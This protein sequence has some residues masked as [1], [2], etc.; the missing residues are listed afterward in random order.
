LSRELRSARVTRFGDFDIVR[1]RRTVA[2]TLVEDCLVM[3]ATMLSEERRLPG[4]TLRCRF[5]G[6]M[7]ND[8][9]DAVIVVRQ[10]GPG[11]IGILLL[12]TRWPR[13]VVQSIQISLKDLPWGG[14]RA[15][16]ECPGIRGNPCGRRQLKLYWPRNDPGAFACR[17][18][19]SLAYESTRRPSRARTWRHLE[20][21][22]GA[23][24]GDT[25]LPLSALLGPGL[26][27]AYTGRLPRASARRS[28]LS[29]RWP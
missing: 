15:Y 5:A 24:A 26:R 14:S 16:F 11:D 8:V 10:E 9:A 1:Y 18:C 28:R 23:I 7:P 12:G 20:V 25:G 2:R 13:E 6:R 17:T 21:I 29:R 22:A 19:H 4:T 27:A 3:D